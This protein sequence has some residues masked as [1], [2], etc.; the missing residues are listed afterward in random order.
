[1]LSLL[2]F[3]IFAQAP[4]GYYNGTDGLTGA[5]LKTKLSE[6]ITNGHRDRGYGALYT[7][8]AAGDIDNF[9]ENDGTILDIYSENPSGTDPYNFRP[10]GPRCGNYGRE[11]DCFNREHM[12]PQST[13]NLGIMKND[14]YQ[15]IPTDGYVNNQRGTYVF[16]NVKNATWTSLNGSKIGASNV[17]GYSGTMFEPIDEFKGDVAR[18]ILYFATRYEKNLGGVSFAMFGNQ[19]YPGVSNWALPML[20]QWNAQDPVSE[21][22]RARNNAGYNFQGNRNPYV[23]HPEFV[24]LVW[25]NS[26]NDTEAPSIPTNLTTNTITS[27]SVQLNWTASTDN[28]AVLVYEIFVDDVLKGTSAQPSYN[29]TGLSPQTSYTFKVR[30]KDAAGNLSAF[31]NIVTATTLAGTPVPPTT[32][33]CGTEN[34]ETIPNANS[35]Y[36]T[37]TWSNNNITWTA[38]DARTDL[39]I[40]GRA[41][42]IRNGSLTSSNISGGI[43]SLSVVLRREFS[44]SSGRFEVLVNGVSKGFLDYNATATTQ[45]LEN[46]NVE[47]NFTLELKNTSTKERVSLD[48]LSWTCYTNTLSTNEVSN[49]RKLSITPNPVKNGTLY[50]SGLQETVKVEIYNTTGLLMHTVDKVSQS[51]NAIQVKHLQKGVY[52]LK[53]G[54]STAKFIIE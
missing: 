32:A 44:G 19:A 54:N 46:I 28:V 34:F 14:F 25:G 20:L 30:A 53:A 24:T 27:S 51:N 7:G 12:V 38:T 50:L 16:G 13:L 36:T 3:Q 48:D 37:R 41:I 21:R 33:T 31:S 18:I 4:A 43:G 47:G 23:D 49:Y 42:T 52:I 39:S 1:M 6:I 26:S 45:R 9:Y 22:E 8:Y 2:G 10:S 35:S 11:G 29:V 5:I 17:S 15:V 40:N